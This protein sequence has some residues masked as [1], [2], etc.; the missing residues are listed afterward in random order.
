MM[1][2]AVTDDL[3]KIAGELEKLG[4]YTV[5]YGEYTGYTDAI[6]YNGD[7]DINSIE[8]SYMPIYN[9]I[10]QKGVLLVNAKGKSIDEIY[11]ILSSK[12]YT[13]LF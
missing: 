13:S 3:R 5:K 8:N 4:V 1:I 7:L 2:V 11:G 12:T 10:T 6:I 9:D